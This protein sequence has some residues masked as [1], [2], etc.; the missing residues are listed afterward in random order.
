[1]TGGGRNDLSYASPVLT[2]AIN[3]CAVM[4][5]KVAQDRRRTLDL[6]VT[7]LMLS[8]TIVFA[9]MVANSYVSRQPSAVQDLSVPTQPI[10]LAGAMVEGCDSTRIVIVQYSDFECPA[11][12]AFA[13]DV[14]PDLR[15]R[16]IANCKARFAFRNLPVAATHEFALAAAEAASCAGHQG[17][18][19]AMHDLIFRQQERLDRGA[20]DLKSRRLGLDPAAFENCMNQHLSLTQIRLDAGEAV[21]VGVAATP[22]FLV[23]V[24]DESKV[25]KV[26]RRLTGSPTAAEL[27][28]IIESLL[29]VGR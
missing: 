21:T 5:V 14:L 24:V 10:S 15:Q 29:G 16:Y 23:G 13:R 25:L 20:L 26:A 19:W 1:M 8:L 27:E 12:G 9:G 2:R 22:T 18:F 17:Q 4:T 28:K 6:V 7:V 11:C 3:G